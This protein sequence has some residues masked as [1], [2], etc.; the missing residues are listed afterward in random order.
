MLILV[1]DAFAT[2]LKWY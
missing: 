2:L 1:V